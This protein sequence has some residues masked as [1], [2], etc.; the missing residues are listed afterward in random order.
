MKLTNN[1][2][3]QMTKD[4]NRTDPAGAKSLLQK[5]STSSRLLIGSGS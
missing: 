3:K 2:T 4:K 1:T 5:F